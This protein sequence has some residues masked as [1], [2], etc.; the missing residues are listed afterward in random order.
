MLAPASLM[1]PIYQ[2]AMSLRN[3]SASALLLLASVSTNVGAASSLPAGI[4]ERGQLVAIHREPSDFRVE[5]LQSGMQIRTHDVVKNILFY[6]PDIVRV[7]T[8]LGTSYAAHPSIVVTL[9][10]TDVHLEVKDS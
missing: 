9:K 8:T 10:P 1:R 6:G 7:N 4:D 3:L 5:R 2:V